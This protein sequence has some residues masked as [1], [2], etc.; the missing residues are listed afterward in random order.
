MYAHKRLSSRKLTRL[1]QNVQARLLWAQHPAV[2]SN[3]G[4]C[5]E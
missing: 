3:E 2:A 5:N 4:Y 1:Y